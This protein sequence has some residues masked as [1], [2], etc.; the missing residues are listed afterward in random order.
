MKTICHYVLES[1]KRD[2]SLV[3]LKFKNFDSWNEMSWTTYFERIEKVAFSLMASG[4][5]PKDK[6]AILSN[7]RAEWS[8]CDYAI[9]GIGAITIPIYHSITVDDLEY[10]INN[11]EAK[12]LFIENKS[13]L[14]TWMTIASKCPQVQKVVCFDAIQSDD[15]NVLAWDS[16][17]NNGQHL[18]ESEPQKFTESCNA[19]K[20]DDTATILYTSGTTGLPKG[21]VLLHSCIMSEVGEAFP[22]LGATP[23]DITL[24]FLPYAHVLGRI[25]HWG[26]MLIGYTMA[27]AESIEKLRTNILEI[28]PTFMISVP[29]IFE[30]IYNAIWTQAETQPTKLKLFRW[31]L[32][33]GLKVSDYKTKRETPPLPLMASY[34]VANKLV[35]SKIKE[36][37]GGRLRFAISGGAPLSSEIAHF[38]HAADVLVLE[39]YGLT[40]TTAAVCV[41]TTFDY[42]FGTVGKPIGDVKVKIAEDG[43]ILLKSA[44]IMKAY[45]KDPEATQ[46]TIKD[47][48][49]HTGDIGE[50]TSSGNLRITDRKK[51][52][53]KT[54]GG[55][56]V[57]PQRLESL[58]KLHPF[59]AN[60][61]IHGDQ[62]KYIVA[63]IT[64]DK[65]YIIQF[66]KDKGIQ[67]SD[68]R[69][70]AQAPAVQ[71]LVRKAVTEVN[72]Q[73][74]SF[75]SIK[76]FLILPN[77]F[78]VESGELT[79]SL[80]VKRKFLDQKFRAEI[81]GLY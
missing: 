79:P 5:Q 8:I 74:A 36:A 11:S 24:S 14:K 63:L 39:G 41:N 17:L 10:I 64:L 46:N 35:L 16:F 15:E 57:A 7:T 28:R 2:P 72:G 69:E 25:E 49:F 6:V 73:L 31:A 58:L 62:K 34:L 29:R 78:T 22:L 56:Y 75:E 54:A 59:V 43:E 23:A 38:F 81:E 45:Y 12:V 61:L 65:P 40:E 9:M 33:V 55:K 51:D 37:L 44:K 21:V 32:A 1:I 19:V 80:K 20:L 27:Y 70:L 76:R 77:E 18:L 53:I 50:L 60:V 42:Q 66:A 48:W 3:A 47:G 68:Y 30:K 67:Y 26:H 71:E 13:L 4:V 52:L